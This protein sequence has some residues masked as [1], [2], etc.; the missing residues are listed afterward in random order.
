MAITVVAFNDWEKTLDL[1]LGNGQMMVLKHISDQ[2]LA[3]LRSAFA[4]QADIPLVTSDIVI[5]Q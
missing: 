2:D 3:D 4:A 5:D 1:D